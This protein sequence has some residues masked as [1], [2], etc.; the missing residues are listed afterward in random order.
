MN[1]SV[2]ES[3]MLT[4]KDVQKILKIGRNRAYDIFKRSDFPAI[5]IGRKYVVEQNAFYFW[6]QKR[7]EKKVA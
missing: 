4:V 5:L 2:K 1:K 6:L 7:R 3:T